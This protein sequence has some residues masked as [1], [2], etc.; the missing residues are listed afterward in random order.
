MENNPLP[1]NLESNIWKMMIHF[2]TNKRPY[3]LF[4]TI[5]LL[6][7][8]NA[9]A[10]TIGLLT[11]V[12][13]L[14]GFILEI[15][16]GYISDKIG[17]KNALILSRA[18][19]VFSTACYVFAHSVPWFFVGA[20]FLTIGTAFAS[21]TTNAFLHDTLI[22]IKKEKNFAAI[23][24]K[25][26]SIGFIVPSL[27]IFILSMIAEQGLRLVFIVSLISDIVGLITIMSLVNPPKEHSTGETSVKDLLNIFK[28]FLKMPWV[29]F[30]LIDS[31]SFGIL[32]GALMGFQN[33]YQEILGFSLF[34]IGILW[35]LSRLFVSSLLLINGHVHN[36]LSFS[37]FTIL[38]IFIYGFLFIGIGFTQNMWLVAAL[39]IVINMTAW[40]LKSAE[41]QYDL[42]YINESDSKATL[43]S[44]KSFVSNLFSGI[45]GL[46]MGTLVFTYSYQEAYMF[47]GTL[48]IGVVTFAVFFLKNKS[49]ALKRNL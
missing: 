36:V 2:S 13:Q 28:T 29:R 32:F 40:G 26:R 20:I 34:S 41:S 49:L 44:M 4:L 7:M 16:S 14:A 19:L 25:I 5:F 24:G 42:E 17:H 33:P 1:K 48:L 6:T 37:Q 9:T 43:L 21:G 12:G 30:V 11:L 38:R 39:F 18:S 46:L 15:P 10:Q 8:P 47:M 3:L 45:F 23:T 31:L 22:A 35:I 27:F